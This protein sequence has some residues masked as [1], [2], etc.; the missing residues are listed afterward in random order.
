MTTQTNEATEANQAENKPA[1]MP[2]MIVKQRVGYGKK[3]SSERLGVAWLNDDGSIYVKLHGTQLISGG[4]ALYPIGD[5]D[6]AAS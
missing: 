2:T 1:N 6:K 5:E 3:A 4:F